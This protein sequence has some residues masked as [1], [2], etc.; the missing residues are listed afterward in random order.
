MTF[1]RS[2]AYIG[3]LV[4]DLVTKGTEEPYRILTS[5]AE[6]RLLLRQDNADLRLTEK[7]RKIGLVDDQRYEKF[8]ERKNQI[9]E[10]TE[11]LEDSVINPGDEHGEKLLEEL[12]SS[13]L[14][15]SMSIGEILKR[16][17]LDSSHIER[18]LPGSEKYPRDVQEQVWIEFKY[19]GYIKK[20]IKQVENFKK[21]ENRKIPPG[22]EFQG[23]RGM[24]MEAREKLQ[25]SKP[26]S[27]GQASRIPGVS[28]ADINMLLI[29][30]EQR[31]R[32][33]GGNEDEGG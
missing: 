22:I 5:R 10:L 19:E 33:T 24:R 18:F 15:K 27:V 31:R 17:E 13:P 25:E 6:Y 2:E 7:G 8:I 12:S 32:E 30:L 28:P 29:Y 3:V 4:D 23:I 14:K 11:I 1:S 26:M 16:P 20:Q 9:E 21:L